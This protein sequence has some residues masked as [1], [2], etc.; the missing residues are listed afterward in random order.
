MAVTITA[1][2]F[3]TASPADKARYLRNKLKGTNRI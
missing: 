3:F 2:G 1:D